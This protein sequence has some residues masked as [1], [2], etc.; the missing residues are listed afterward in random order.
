MHDLSKSHVHACAYALWKWVVPRVE[1]WSRKKKNVSLLLCLKISDKKLTVSTRDSHWRMYCLQWMLPVLFVPKSACLMVVQDQMLVVLLYL[2]A[3]FI[4]RRPC[5]LCV[6]V[7][8]VAIFVTCI[9]GVG[10]LLVCEWSSSFLFS[11]MCSSTEDAKSWSR[12]EKSSRNLV[13]TDAL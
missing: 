5:I 10:H 6:L 4:E 8:V 13:T 1:A 7:F 9:S 12:N 3:F 11:S 2:L